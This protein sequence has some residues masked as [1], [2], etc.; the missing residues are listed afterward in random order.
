MMREVMDIFLCVS[1]L[2][3][4]LSLLLTYLF[5]VMYRGIYPKMS[6][7]FCILARVDIKI[8]TDSLLVYDAAE[9]FCFAFPRF[10]DS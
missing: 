7:Y 10:C 6:C 5:S 9:N 8:V 3:Y 4:D 1:A 2:F